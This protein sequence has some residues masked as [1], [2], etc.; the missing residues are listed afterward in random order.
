MS[1]LEETMNKCQFCQKET[2]I[3]SHFVAMCLPIPRME[4]MIDKWG[5]KDWFDNLEKDPSSFTPE[6]SNELE[7]MCTYDQ[8]LNT[9]GRGYMCSECIELEDKLLNQYYPPQSDV[10]DPSKTDFNKT[11]CLPPF[12]SME[13][14][15]FTEDDLPF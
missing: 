12:P 8:L 7:E 15:G 14:I 6:Q 2:E 13:D 4:E 1:K 9:I 5:R 10:I 3:P 11:T